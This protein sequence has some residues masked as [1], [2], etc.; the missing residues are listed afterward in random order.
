M[1]CSPL[2]IIVDQT[3][4]LQSPGDPFAFADCRYLTESNSKPLGGQLIC[5]LIG[6]IV[7]QIILLQS[8]VPLW[9]KTDEVTS[10]LDSLRLWQMFAKAF[11]DD[12]EE[13]P[14]S[15]HNT[16]TADTSSLSLAIPR[17]NSPDVCWL[18]SLTLVNTISSPSTTLPQLATM[19]NLVSLHIKGDAN[20]TAETCMI[21]DDSIRHWGKQARHSGGFPRLKWLFLRHQ[22]GVTEAS[23]EHLV[24]FP[25]LDQVVTSQCGVRI[26][27]AMTI[28]QDRGFHA[29]E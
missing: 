26:V 29:T 11:H 4:T 6:M 9:I 14:E 28:V 7:D 12:G 18:T 23:L 24:A 20:D 16:T 22:V 1:F 13:I 19:S 10:H 3:I 8:P 15:L 5:A 2:G 17:I 27:N 25:V 21:N